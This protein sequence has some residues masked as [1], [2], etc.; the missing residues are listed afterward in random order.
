MLLSS[1]ATPSA[2]ASAALCALDSP[3]DWRS[4]VRPRPC[5]PPTSLPFTIPLDIA[6]CC[7][8]HPLDHVFHHPDHGIVAHVAIEMDHRALVCVEYAHDRGLELVQVQA[9]VFAK[10][11]KSIRVANRH[12]LLKFDHKLS[13][14]VKREPA[15]HHVDDHDGL[16]GTRGFHQL[17]QAP[18]SGQHIF[19]RQQD[20]HVTLLDTLIY[21]FAQVAQC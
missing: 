20:H 5:Q 18:G 13:A 10:Q 2:S 16:A 7:R 12:L 17:D 1:L 14:F 4:L 9:E 8:S 19:G 15:I 11:V 6:V 21:Q 3:L